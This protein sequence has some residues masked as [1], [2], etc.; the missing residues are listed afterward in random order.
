LFD[1]AEGA[2]N[3]FVAFTLLA[4]L[5]S[6][7]K[8][9]LH[10]LQLI[11]ELVEPGGD[12]R[13]GHDRV[14]AHAAANPVGVAL[15]AAGELLLLHLAERVA[16]FRGSGT[17]GALEVAD[18]ALH[19]LLELLEIV[20]FTFVR[21][22]ELLGLIARDAA[23]VGAELLAHLAFELLLLAGELVGLLG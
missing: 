9:L 3:L 11:A 17:S 14:L 4:V 8:L 22:G 10:L 13:L 23:R 7:A 12:L 2:L 1:L 18:G 6:R 16:E 20:D 15:H 19:P 21:L 5:G